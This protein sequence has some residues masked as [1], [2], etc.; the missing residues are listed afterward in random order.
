M[1]IRVSLLFIFTFLFAFPIFA[2]VDTE[3]WFA[4]P[5]V[6]SQHADNPVY[7]RI[8]SLQSA[9]TVTISQPANPSFKTITRSMAANST[10]SLD[11]TDQLF[12]LENTPPNMV[13]NYGVYISATSPITAYYEVLGSSFWGIGVNSDIFVLKGNHA[14]GTEF[15]V[16]FQTH[17]DNNH[18][19][20]NDVWASFDIVATENN[21][22]V[23]I[24]PT[25]DIV[26]HAAGATYTVTLQKGQTYSARAVSP[27]AGDHPSGSHVTSNKPIAIT[28]K[29]DSITEAAN[30]DLIGDQIIPVKYTGK[31][32]IAIKISEN[33]YNTDR[34][35]IVGTKAGTTVSID[36]TA[37][38]TINAG[39]TYEYQLLNPTAYIN[40]S[41][42]VYVWHVGGFT[43][44]LGSAILPPLACTG[45]RRVNFTRSTNE[46]FVIE[47][48]VRTGYEQYFKLN[49]STTLVPASAFQTVPATGGA[50]KYADIPLDFDIVPAGSANLLQNDSADFQ[51]STLNG[52][53]IT[54]FR[55]GYFSDFGFLDLGP[56]KSYCEGNTVTLD[57]GFYQDSITWN[58]GV[59]TQFITVSDTGYYWVKT[60]KGVC[61]NSDTIHLSY[62]PKITTDVLGNDTSACAQSGLTISTLF[63]FSSYQWTT[64]STAA[65]ISPEQSGTYGIT[66]KNQYGCPKSDHLVVTIYPLPSPGIIYNSDLES[67]C[68]NPV[69]SLE[70]NDTFTSYQWNTGDTTKS[71]TT[72]HN[73]HDL[74]TLTVSNTDGCKQYTEISIDCS[75]V[76]GLVPNLLTPNDD[77]KNDIFYIEYL[78]YG[79]WTLEV[80]NRWGDRV[81]QNKGYDNSFDPKSL[82]DGIYYFSF[83]HNEGKGAHKG[84][85]Q[86]IR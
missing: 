78:R 61:V 27:L 38:A 33:T 12:L 53:E 66:V 13:L 67:F 86:I 3:F 50:W 41:D 48:V 70:A 46:T 2:Q 30:Y 1:T 65:A 21:T 58:T 14:L 81:Y 26:G 25:K 80:Y 84:W 64:G 56:D 42:S 52:A 55:F 6:S 17:W 4:A 15:Y 45:S 82:S 63:P 5:E 11:L 59:K 32:Y 62:Y 39:E 19:V 44:E 8:S 29:D 16:P 47:I 18:N 60:K 73:E 22:V 75:P 34:L 54:G 83:R 35:Y 76:I 49:G 23:T 37:V 79:T 51:L 10:L 40:A 85:L 69:V 36:G 71:I 77:G 74:Y 68:K 24:T 9:T 31:E 20:L 28:T 57:A 72:T 7:L 43:A